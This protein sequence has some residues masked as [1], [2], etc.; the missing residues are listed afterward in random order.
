[1]E[2]RKITYNHTIIEY[3]LT[4][5]PVKN[6]N[7][8]VKPDGQINVSAN[9]RIPLNKIDDFVYQNHDFIF[10]AL[11]KYETQ[12]KEKSLET[13]QYQNGETFR[14]LEKNL[15]LVLTE[16]E[17]EFVRYDDS[18]LYLQVQ[19]IHDLSIKKYLISKWYHNMTLL[20][21]QKKC[22]EVYEMFQSHG[23][24]VPHPKLTIRS[25]TSRWGSCRPDRS[26][27]TL[28]SKLIMEHEKSI[29]SVV[30]HEFA[31]FIHPNHSK[32]FYALVQTIMPDYRYWEKKLM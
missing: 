29:E 14:F 19:D 26:S 32:Q 16:G 6:I 4:L 3:N 25:M 18:F 20:T 2:R 11:K 22:D 21:F 23:Y 27:I 12:R 5:K 1:M 8:R 13:K 9:P 30:V 15:T 28:N 17:Q 24:Q 10:Q 7:L 31:H